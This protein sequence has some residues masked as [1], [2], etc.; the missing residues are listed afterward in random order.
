MQTCSASKQAKISY[1]LVRNMTPKTAKSYFVAQDELVFKRLLPE[2]SLL[3]VQE[4][5]KNAGCICTVHVLMLIKK[6]YGMSDF[7]EPQNP[8]GDKVIAC[9]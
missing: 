6:W 4:N 7:S 8:T 9:C 5:Y 2:Q 3:K 1:A